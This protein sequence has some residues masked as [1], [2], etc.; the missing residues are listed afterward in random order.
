MVELFTS[1]FYLLGVSFHLFQECQHSIF[2]PVQEKPERFLLLHRRKT[3]GF[4][5]VSGTQPSEK[6]TE[7]HLESIRN[8]ISKAFDHLP[9]PR[10]SSVMLKKALNAER[11]LLT[12]QS[13]HLKVENLQATFAPS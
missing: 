3:S 5:S 2:S 8:G 9:K 10:N 6:S 12:R 13:G 1:R 7:K 4:R 11:M